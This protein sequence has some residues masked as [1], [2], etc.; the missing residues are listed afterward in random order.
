MKQNRKYKIFRRKNR[1]ESNGFYNW[2]E[3]LNKMKEQKSKTG[4]KSFDELAEMELYGRVL[5]KDQSKERLI[6]ED[7]TY[8]RHP[9]Q[10]IIK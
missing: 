7:T 2:R 4:R 9:Y 1:R 6:I 5:P 10:D 3:Y 8:T